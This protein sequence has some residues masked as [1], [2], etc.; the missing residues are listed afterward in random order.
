MHF[1][2]HYPATQFTAGST[3]PASIPDRLIA[4]VEYLQDIR[5]KEEV[6]AGISVDTVARSLRFDVPKDGS[7]GSEIGSPVPGSLRLSVLKGDGTAAFSRNVAVQPGEELSYSITATDLEELQRTVIVPPGTLVKRF[8]R[9]AQLVPIGGA[10]LDFKNSLFSVQSIT[11]TELRLFEA[12]GALASFGFVH[13][14]TSAVEVDAQMAAPLQTLNWSAAQIGIDGRFELVFERHVK[15]NEEPVKTI[16]WLWWLSGDGSAIGFVP[17]D[18][19]VTVVRDL[20]ISLPALT[21]LPGSGH[22]SSEDCDCDRSVTSF[23]YSEAELINNPGLYNEDPGSFCKP[24]SNPERIVSEKSFSV[25]SR[26][27]QPDI[28]PLPSARLKSQQLLDLDPEP[29]AAPDPRPTG[30]VPRPERP[31]GTMAIAAAAPANIRVVNIDR[32]VLL[33]SLGRGSKPTVHTEPPAVMQQAQAMPSGRTTMDAEHPVQWEDN[34][35]QY[36]ACSV[37]LGHILEFRVRTRSNGYSLGTVASTLTLAPRQTKRIQKVEFERVERARR[38]ERQQ[39]AD[40]VSD[41]VSRERDYN[42]TV[43]SYLS[44]WA[45]GS[46]ESGSAAAAGGFGFAIPPF[47]GGVGG[48]TSTAWSSSEQEGVRNVSAS[49]QQRLRD[50]IRRHGDALRRYQSTVVTEVTQQETV[51]GTTEVLRNPNYGHSLTVIYYQILRHLAVT[52]EFAGVRECLYVPFAIKPFTLQRAYRWRE[53]LGKYLRNPRLSRNMK[54][55]RD[56]ITDFATSTVKPGSRASQPLTYVRGSIYINM[57]VERPVD[58]EEG[59]FDAAQWR[60]YS[61]FFGAPAYGIWAKLAAQ[62]GA[63]RDALF[64]REHAPTI[65]SKW[66]NKLQV[67]I[68]TSLIK[69]DFTMATRYAFNQTVRV[70]FSIPAHELS[71]LTRNSL[72]NITIHS[73]VPL[74]PGSVANVTRMQIRYGTADFERTINSEAGLDDLV[75]PETGVASTESANLQF[76]TDSW[77][78]VNEQE[79]MRQG[80]AELIEHFNEH[81]EFYHKAIWWSM[82]RDRLMMM[83]DGFYVP[84]TGTGAGQTQSIASVVDREPIAIIGNALVYRVGAGAFLGIDKILEPKDLYARY[85]GREPAQDPLYISLPTDGL[86]AQTIMDECLALEEHQGSVDWVLNDPDP[87]LG[88]IDP[89]LMMSRRADVSSTLTPSQMPATIINLQ[90]APDAPAPTGLGSVLGAVTNGN[91]FRDMAGLAGTQANAAAALQTAASL[92]TNFGNQAAALKMADVASNAQATQNANQQL[93]AVQSAVDKGLITPEQGSQHANGILGQMHSSSDQAPLYTN[94]DLLAAGSIPGAMVK[95]AGPSGSFEMSSP[96]NAKEDEDVGEGEDPEPAAIL[97]G[98]FGLADG[99]G[100][101][102]GTMRTFD[103][104]TPTNA[105]FVAG[106]GFGFTSP[107]HYEAGQQGIQGLVDAWARKGLV[108]G[109]AFV[110]DTDRNKNLLDVANWGFILPTDDP[111]SPYP[112]T[113]PEGT[114]YH[115]HYIAPDPWKDKEGASWTA[116]SLKA[117]VLAGEAV[118]LSIGDMIMLSGDLVESFADLASAGKTNWRPGPPGPVHVMRGFDQLEPYAVTLLDIKGTNKPTSK[119]AAAALSLG[120]LKQ[121][122]DNKS[123]YGA[124]V[125]DV[126]RTGNTWD[127][128]KAAVAFLNKVRG[129][130][131]CSEL[132]VL[133]RVLR[134]EDDKVATL[135]KLRPG[136][137]GANATAYPID[138]LQTVVSNGHYYE[139][140]SRNHPHFHPHNWDAFESAQQSALAAIDA[141]LGPV[142]GGSVSR[143][144]PIPAEAIGAA[145]FGLHF[146][147]DAFSSGHM[148]VP[149]KALYPDKGIAAKVMHDID[150]GM[151]L[152]VK[153]GLGAQWRAYGDGHMHK[154]SALGLRISAVLPRTT[155]MSRATNEKQMLAAAASAILQLGY[156]AV[157]HLANLESR[158]AAEPDLQP[159]IDILKDAQINSEGKMAYDR[160]VPDASPGPASDTPA[161]WASASVADKLAYMRKHEPIPLPDGSDWMTNTNYNAPALLT[162]RG[163]INAFATFN[164]RVPLKALV[165]GS[166]FVIHEPS[167]GEILDCSEYQLF[168]DCMPSQATSWF[169]PTDNSFG[170]LAKLPLDLSIKLP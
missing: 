40:R 141:V 29:D 13:N 146:L 38:E 10:K 20:V 138:F 164:W 18:L 68:G 67:R 99:H 155:A 103:V 17:D 150:G 93:A 70:D 69:A 114:N 8:V 157:G 30:A 82:D 52:T 165:S 152:F 131:G 3:A 104:S 162:S 108:G 118:T 76:P 19:S 117:A 135:L 101:E 161:S 73:E 124:L 113:F 9:R 48:G 71:G 147:T 116:A 54:Y 126:K 23:N 46:S 154:A 57:A 100:T 129:T 148:R 4:E 36:Q 37:A 156:H 64:Q 59:K 85:A 55:L 2:I 97:R 145:A 78:A 83:L 170:E 121:L 109:G 81:V 119:V 43:A 39:Q 80:V 134:T 115:W 63:A 53:A 58:A 143:P 72:V 28:S 140:A 88:T 153:N 167:I 45:A 65:A 26:V 15:E 41:E 61:S 123:N 160:L 98:D 27:Q 50:A 94:P 158:V 60:P 5:S 22:A 89:S 127:Y 168:I 7:A 102:V 106:T 125:A 42:D 34:I 149:R 56:V 133:S 24:F 74:P 130:T 110:M 92:A 91:S 44:E 12:G 6:E 120:Q 142:V 107:E 77:D 33:R 62:A 95:A 1:T 163:E 132:L 96:A 16:G 14:R 66:L 79:L 166:G 169:G 32:D 137:S 84:D 112:E 31:G 151:G 136:V 111:Q 35:A 159:L 90:N 75:E 11:A 86:Y 47:V 144:A 51:T 49:E 25:I 122:Q 139:L 128:V 87:E 105:P 21:R